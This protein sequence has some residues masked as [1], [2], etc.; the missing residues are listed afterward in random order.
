MQD[1]NTVCYE[2]VLAQVKKGYQVK[3]KIATG[4]TEIFL[5]VRGNVFDFHPEHC[6]KNDMH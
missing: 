4:S 5:H 6:G 3:K 1:M 2:K